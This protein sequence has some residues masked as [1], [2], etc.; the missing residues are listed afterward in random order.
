VTPSFHQDEIL[1]LPGYEGRIRQVAVDGLGR[2]PPTLLL[3]NKLTEK[4]R[5]LL[6]RD[7]GRNW[8]EDALGTSV[9][10]FHLDCLSSEVRLNVDVD[11]ALTVLANGCYQWLGRH[12]RG[13]DKAAPKQLY[14]KFVETGGTVEVES[15]RIVVRFDKRC[16]NPNPA[17][18]GP[19]P[20]RSSDPLAGRPSYRI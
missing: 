6:V 18:R 4:G 7:A 3:S 11:V 20:G 17:R 13:V 2:E 16:H 8:V 9:N 12:L 19:G 1:K 14:R 10:F 5:G 15:Q